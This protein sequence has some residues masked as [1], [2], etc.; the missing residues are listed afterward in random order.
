MAACQ[1]Q[2]GAGTSQKNKYWRA[3]MSYP[4]GEEQGRGRAGQVCRVKDRRRVREEVPR[5][6]Q[7][8]DDHNESAQYIDTRKPGSAR[9]GA[10]AAQ[11]SRARGCLHYMYIHANACRVNPNVLYVCT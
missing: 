2:V 1:G 4:A 7:R 3:E 11:R 6:V 10:L 9:L 5:M 8:H